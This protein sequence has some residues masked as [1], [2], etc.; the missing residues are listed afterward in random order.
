MK[1]RIF[2]ALLAVLLIGGLCVPASADAVVS[3]GTV[4]AGQQ[5]NEYISG[6]DAAMS[7]GLYDSNGDGYPDYSLPAGLRIE[8]TLDA[9][10][11]MYKYYLK[12]APTAAG[13]YIF[14]LSAVYYDG[15]V[16]LI[17]CSLS[18]TPG[19]PTVNI[20]A[21]Q[22]CGLG[23][24]VTISCAAQSGDGGTLL[25]QWYSN[26]SRNT[27]GII[28]PGETNSVLTVTV[29][30]S[31]DSYY[32]CVVTNNNNGQISS[33]T[34]PVTRV[35]A[36]TL[37]SLKIS[38]TPTKLTYEVGEALDTTGL[39][40]TAT[41]TD[42]S[43]KT[44]TD[45]TGVSFSPE[46]FESAGFQSVLVKYM[47]KTCVF[48]V[49]IE[50]AK[51][52][53]EILRMPYN[54]SYT[55]G[56]TIDTTG[57]TLRIISKTGYTDVTD[58]FTCSPKVMTRA[59]QQTITVIYSNGESATFTVS[60]SEAKKEET[61]QIVSFP[62]KRSYT[63]GE[64]LDT[65]GMSLK[66]TSGSTETN[67]S[68]GFTCEPSVFSQAAGSQTVTVTYKSLTAT[69][70][71]SVSESVAAD[72]VSPSPTVAVATIKVEPDSTAK[73]TEKSSAPAAVVV[74][75]VIIAVAALAGAGAYIYLL[76]RGN[77]SGSV[78]EYEE[79]VYAEDD[80]GDYFIEESS[81]AARTPPADSAAPENPLE[82]DKKDYFD[83]L[84]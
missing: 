68:S 7:V 37:Q 10:S 52:Q 66:Y 21:D 32:Y 6:A 77:V 65:T 59:G 54:T 22:S 34:S 24:S 70:T 5:L 14:I 25:Y 43:T 82:P 18:V 78:E 29:T 23:E 72:T 41:Y 56:D 16:V 58:G 81:S 61:L 44:V 12:G 31:E 55:V 20:T 36:A 40:L 42:G 15:T 75:A 4:A 76:K 69:F 50:E 71:V 33:A 47:G 57:L 11:G 80:D 1:K 51:E 73:D 83:G 63:V 39:E 2:V 19:A 48:P 28:I 13:N 26:T 64:S 45:L 60:V 17:N 30:S 79:E 8:Q 27:G 35:S 62:T 84:F 53:V 49:E 3:F 9:G 67:V 74:I 38:K 46:T